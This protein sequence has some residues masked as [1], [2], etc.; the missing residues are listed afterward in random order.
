MPRSMPMIG[1]SSL[2]FDGVAASARTK[3]EA[4]EESTKRRE[5][6]IVN[7]TINKATER[8]VVLFVLFEQKEKEGIF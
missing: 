4:E 1:F 3:V 2:P 8:A 7:A 6:K 5:S